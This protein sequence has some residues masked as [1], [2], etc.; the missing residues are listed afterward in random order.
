MFIEKKQGPSMTEDG[1]PLSVLYPN[2]VISNK[3][4]SMTFNQYDAII[5][6]GE[7]GAKA[8]WFR[9]AQRKAQGIEVLRA[10]TCESAEADFRELRQGFIPTSTI[11]SMRLR[12]W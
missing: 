4:L 6:G 2:P 11:V 10:G 9:H 8:A 5:I 7:S 12:R 1:L 3:E